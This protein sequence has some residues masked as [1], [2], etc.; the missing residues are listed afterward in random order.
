MASV[1]LRFVTM[2]EGD[3]IS[4]SVHPGAAALVGHLDQI[5]KKN[6]ILYL[7][8][9]SREKQKGEEAEHLAEHLEQDGG[10]GEGGAK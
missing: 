1:T 3:H 4:S 8:T 10:D 6:K 9:C 2:I 7:R 5:G